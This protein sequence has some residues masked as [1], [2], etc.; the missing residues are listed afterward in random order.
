M[1]AEFRD[2]TTVRGVSNVLQPFH[3]I[4]EWQLHAGLDNLEHTFHGVY[5]RNVKSGAAT[6][7]VGEIGVLRH[8]AMHVQPRH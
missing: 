6:A 8:G 7:T 5:G 3:G 1:G 2:L 4:G